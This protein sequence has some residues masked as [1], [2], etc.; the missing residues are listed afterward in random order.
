MN[1]VLEALFD[2]KLDEIAPTIHF[3]F[4]VFSLDLVK[5]TFFDLKVADWEPAELVLVRLGKSSGYLERGGRS[6]P[7]ATRKLG[8]STLPALSIADATN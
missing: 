3:A 7:Q 6:E 4:K 1:T 5:R 2:D 8:A